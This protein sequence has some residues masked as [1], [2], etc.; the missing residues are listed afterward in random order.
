MIDE[1]R[2]SDLP[3]FSRMA[4]SS[5]PVWDRRAAVGKRHHRGANLEMARRHRSDGGPRSRPRGRTSPMARTQSVVA[6]RP[7][8]AEEKK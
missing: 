8:V 4:W 1:Q 3:S 5:R 7:G 2:L 6:R